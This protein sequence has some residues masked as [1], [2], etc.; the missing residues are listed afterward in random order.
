MYLKWD[1][2]PEG[3]GQAFL[4][5]VQRQYVPVTPVEMPVISI[6][7][8]SGT[9]EQPTL[10]RGAKASFH[11]WPRTWLRDSLPRIA[12]LVW[13]VLRQSSVSCYRLTVQPCLS[14]QVQD[15]P[16]QRT[17]YSA[18]KTGTLKPCAVKALHS[19]KGC[20]DENMPWETLVSA[21]PV[22]PTPERY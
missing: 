20:T 7:T 14:R 15:P 11:P 6:T 10:F 16:Y 22:S 18:S 17:A 2:G 9:E 19:S 13:T 3:V 8:R 5:L 1:E 12:S 4:E 21:T